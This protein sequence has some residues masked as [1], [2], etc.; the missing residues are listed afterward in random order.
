LNLYYPGLKEFTKEKVLEGLDSKRIYELAK[1]IYG[2]SNNI[3]GFYKYI[4]KVKK[5]LTDIELKEYGEDKQSIEDKF[6]T[7]LEKKKMI[8]G[9]EICEELSCS[10]SEVYDLIQ[11]FRGMGYEIIVD[12]KRITLS[13]NATASVKKL[14]NSLEENEI[15]FG[16]ASDLHFGSKACQ[17]TALNEFCDICIKK[18]VRYIFVP[19][20]I[21]AGYNVYP[22]QQY[23]VYALSAKEQEESVIVNLPRGP[24]EWYM[25]GGNHDY[26]FIKRGGGH[27]PILS[28]ESQRPD[29]HY[30]GFDD[31]DIPILN[32]V[33]VKLF[34]PDGAVP[35][36]VSYKMQKTVE[37]IAYSELAKLCL[38]N[39]QSPSIRFLLAGHLHV[40]CQAIFGTIFAAQCGCFE[41]QTG[42]LK[43]KGLNP[44]V[45]GYIVQA[46]L[47]KK[48]GIILNFDA[49]YYMFPDE[50]Q[51]D[52]KN[53]NHTLQDNKQIK[54][55]LFEK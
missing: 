4:S 2:Y 11:H 27:N 10:P 19:G 51:D 55:P 29:V 22:G 21:V 13:N 1:N 36:S 44:L 9:D 34:H 3:R 50:I 37:Q 7:I 39:K 12:E 14:N 6:I 45:G 5:S 54:K 24:F 38:S 32:G 33:D 20:D 48:D 43:R 25:M 53:Y 46:T 8:N 16:V 28:I 40:Q 17:I 31:V 23:E 41:G 15:V 47:R 35:Y 30:V 26:S 42:Y 49:K 18:G 52:W